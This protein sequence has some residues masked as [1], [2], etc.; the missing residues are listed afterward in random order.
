MGGP[1]GIVLP[2]TKHDK[3]YLVLMF[4]GPFFWCALDKLLTY[5]LFYFKPSPFYHEKLT[6]KSPLK[7]QKVVHHLLYII[8]FIE[9]FVGFG[10][11]AVPELIRSWGEWDPYARS[12]KFDRAFLFIGLSNWS[13]YLYDFAMLTYGAWK[14]RNVP[15]VDKWI[16]IGAELIHHT[17]YITAGFLAFFKLSSYSVTILYMIM[18]VIEIPMRWCADIL[19]AVHQHE[20]APQAVLAAAGK[21]ELLRLHD[22]FSALPWLM[23]AHSMAVF[24][25][26]REGLMAPAHDRLASSTGIIRAYIA[27]CV[28]LIA[29]DGCACVLQGQTLVTPRI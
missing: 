17:V 7:F 3:T 5:G 2:E 6:V 11:L 1:G 14:D 10:V 12:W 18:D 21:L 29:S 4:G 28:A 26:V 8:M 15:G 9:T 16:R 23:A 27:C 13:F 20:P 22:L 25:S 19:P 24:A